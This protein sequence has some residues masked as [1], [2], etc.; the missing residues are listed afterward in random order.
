MY[1]NTE[2]VVFEVL[3]KSQVPTGED[4]LMNAFASGKPYQ[5]SVT[6]ETFTKHIK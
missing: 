5:T 6:D 4:M 2:R 3:Q 1:L